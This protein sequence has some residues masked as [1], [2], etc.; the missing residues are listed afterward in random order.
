M[1]SPKP[2]PPRRA[3]R[4]KRWF[5]TLLLALLIAVSAAPQPCV[6]AAS[7]FQNHQAPLA[8]D[9]LDAPRPASASRR[10][11]SLSATDALARSHRPWMV[12]SKEAILGKISGFLSLALPD[13][14]YFSWDIDQFSEPQDEATLDSGLFGDTTG[15]NWGGSTLEVV[16]SQAIFLTRSA[17]F[18]PHITS[19]DGLK[20]SLL[21]VSTFYRVPDNRPQPGDRANHACPYE[22]GP[23]W[24]RN[25]F[26]NAYEDPDDRRLYSSFV[27][28]TT[29]TDDRHLQRDPQLPA[30]PQDWIALVERGGGCGFAEKVRVAQALGAIAVVVGDAPSPDWN[31]GHTGDPNEE[32]DPGLSGKRLV[33]MYAPGD[34]SDIRIPSTFVTRPSYLDLSRLVEEVERDDQKW[35]QSHRRPSSGGNRSHRAPRGLEVVISKDDMMFEWPLIDLGILLLLLPS[36]MTVATVIVHRIRMIRQRRKERAPELVVLGLPCLIWRSGGQPWEKIEGPDVDP[37]PGNG[38]ASPGDCDA[39]AAPSSRTNAADADADF[40]AQEPRSPVA[41]LNPGDLESGTA[42][43]SIPL[44]QE[45]ENG[46][47]PSRRPTSTAKVMASPQANRSHSFLPPGRTYF[48]TDECAICLCDFVD[49]DRVRVLPCGHIFHR[50]EIDDWLVRIKKLC[51]ICKRDITVPIPPAPP[52]PPIHQASTSSSIT[53]APASS[54]ASDAPQASQQQGSAQ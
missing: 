5:A 22:G 52:G 27:K 28:A 50:Q 44:L 20:G 41:H 45:D 1:A 12:A 3:M 38:G 34:T 17:A 53:E 13:P 23:G 42:A 21:P 8:Q 48:S 40:N 32:S 39:S 37:G 6:A 30:P 11:P 36:F 29:E 19:D 35:Q 25:D 4:T 7:V 10:P 9:P 24:R 47:G 16:R 18:G 43:E 33:T 31:G 2:S 46:A 54:V 26:L 15:L 14:R 51:P 49:G